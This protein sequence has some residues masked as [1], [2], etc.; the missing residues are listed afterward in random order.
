MPGD[1]D[2]FQERYLAFGLSLVILNDVFDYLDS[3]FSI[4]LYDIFFGRPENAPDKWKPAVPM[5]PPVS[6]RAWKELEQGACTGERMRPGGRNLS[7]QHACS[8]ARDLPPPYGEDRV[9]RHLIGQSAVDRR[10]HRS[11]HA[12]SE[13]PGE[14]A[15]SFVPL[16]RVALRRTSRRHH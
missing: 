2:F 11:D 3:S 13:L 14:H 12:S 9:G 16:L 1:G 6:V 8:Q 5:N 15:Q 4:D 7:V 10:G